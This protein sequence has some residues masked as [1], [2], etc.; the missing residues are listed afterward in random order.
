[1]ILVDNNILSTFARVGQ[2]ELLFRL[3]PK[4]TLARIIHGPGKSAQC[5]PHKPDAQVLKL[6][7][8]DWRSD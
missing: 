1:M 6:R 4:D 2:L 7:F 3:F 8:F 5:A